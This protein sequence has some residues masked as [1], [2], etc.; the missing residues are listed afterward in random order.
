MSACCRNYLSPS[1][2]SASRRLITTLIFLPVLL[3]A[4]YRPAIS[5]EIDDESDSAT[6]T[7]LRN[8]SAF[9]AGQQEIDTIYR[10]KS[11]AVADRIARTREHL[12]AAEDDLAELQEKISIARSSLSRLHSF[13]AG[14]SVV[15]FPAAAFIFSRLSVA[16]DPQTAGTIPLFIFLMLTAVNLAL[17]LHFRCGKDLLS[18]YRIG[19]TIL[20]VFIICAFAAPLLAAEAAPARNEIAAR[21]KMTEKI[22]SATGYRKYIA[23]LETA[24]AGEMEIPALQSGSQYLQVFTAMTVP[25]ARYHMTLAALYTH[26]KQTNRAVQAIEQLMEMDHPI[27]SAEFD[28]II[29][30]SIKF[31]I[32]QQKTGLVFSGIARQAGNLTTATALL[33]LTAVVLENNRPDLC[34]MLLSLAGEKATS[35]SELLRLADL[36]TESGQ[37][38]QAAT[39]LSIAVERARTIQDLITV[40]E[41]AIANREEPILARIL[42]RVAEISGK[43]KEPILMVDFLVDHGL[44]KEAETVFA[45]M[46]DRVSP[47][48]NDFT[49]KL[50]FLIYAA[51][52][53]NFIEQA[54]SAT[55]KLSVYLGDAA[56][57][58]TV[59][60]II[61]RENF[62]GIP[63]I[64]QVSLP[65]F[66]GLLNEELARNQQAE[67][68]YIRAV[69]HTLAGIE[70]SYGDRL[71]D[72]LN[73]FFL[74][75]R[76][77]V[78]EKPPPELAGLDR[79]YTLLEKRFL[80]HQKEDREGRLAAEN[81]KLIALQDTAAAGLAR[82][83]TLQEQYD[84][85]RRQLLA[86]AAA[87]IAA[88]IFLSV[89]FGG[90]A[91][92]AYRYSRNFSRYR[93]YVFFAKFIELASWVK[94]LSLIG[95]IS[96]ILGIFFAKFL[97]MIHRLYEDSATGTE[98][99]RSVSIQE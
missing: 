59:P 58:Y 60:P 6:L 29:V 40:A 85:A 47:S 84:S 75:G 27:L 36:Y 35:T 79:T 15:L 4:V 91:L 62:A 50:L 17:Y 22:L 13:F 38:D 52:E 72:S 32:E 68:A 44:R 30:Q 73:P 16:A 93:T 71:P 34:G 9:L 24:P 26:E 74:L 25:S 80:K 61:H 88:T 86:A 14:I 18:R 3:L 21:L 69:L 41:P 64:S 97:L 11:A 89:L 33:E 82:L 65:L 20:L 10:Q 53:R 51:L 95:L 54:V 5:R 76:I 45:A 96:G 66:Y 39:A 90:C 98:V 1:P 48:T 2:P 70:Q 23:A 87:G 42:S 92:L 46:D 28:N 7:Y 77:W 99:R 43:F 83:E 55:S 67:T 31:L 37:A 78:R 49:D 94:I 57:R 8:R 81:K 56:Y 19:L 12:T 63:D